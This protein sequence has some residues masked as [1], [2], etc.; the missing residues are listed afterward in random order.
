MLGALFGVGQQVLG[1]AL[2]AVGVHAARPGA[3]DRAG[4]EVPPL[5]AHQHLGAGADERHVRRFEQHHVRARVDHA[6]R[7]VEGERL[8]PPRHPPA[9]GE[10]DLEDVPRGDV[11]LGGEHGAAEGAAVEARQ[12]G[13]GR[14]GRLPRHGDAAA[15]RLLGEQPRQARQLLLGLL[16]AHLPL[17][18][19]GD[20]QHPLVRVVEDDQGVEAGEQ[21]HGEIEGIGRAVRQPLDEADQVVAEVADEAAGERDGTGLGADRWTASWRASS[22]SPGRRSRWPRRSTSRWSG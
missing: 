20:R 4:L 15:A 7:A 21:R 16:E 3:G 12:V 5:L 18:L 10:H 6:Q 14:P 9:A 2:V 22:G 17:D 13:G 19:V 1:Q 8:D 11:L